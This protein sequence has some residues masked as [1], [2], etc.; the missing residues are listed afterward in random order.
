M[1]ASVLSPSANAYGPGYVAADPAHPNDIYLG[2]GAPAGSSGIW[3]STDYG[4]TWTQIQTTV[5]G[6]YSIAVA[7]TTPATL[8]TG[9]WGSYGKLY[10][11]NDGGGTFTVVGSGGLAADFYS[12]RVD[13]YDPNHV[14]SGLH[15]V[16]GVV[17]SSDGGNTWRVVG[18]TGWPS[19]GISWFPFFLDTGDATTTRKTWLAIAQDGAS[20]V[21]TTDGGGQWSIPTGLGGLQHPHGNSQIYQDGNT[22]FVAGLQGPGPGVYRSTD[23]GVTWS[24]AD[25]GSSPEAVVWG[26]SKNVY[27]MWAWACSDCNLGTGFESASQPGTS[28]ATEPSST[29]TGLQIGAS[30]MAVGFDGTH[31]VMVGTFW[32]QGLWRYVEP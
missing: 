28:W 17:E 1:P 10:K 32:A 18:G 2:G 14:I 3:K 25:S 21:R 9:L 12:L 19:G 7:G 13:R 6:C 5:N 22:V 8:Y 11:S 24:L 20:A 30:S 15:E 29:T 23:L 31:S 26:T 27:A 4:F 16:D